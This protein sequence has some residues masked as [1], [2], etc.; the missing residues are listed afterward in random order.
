MTNHPEPIEWTEEDE[1]ELRERLRAV[2][3]PSPED[4]WTPKMQEEL[5]VL[6]QQEARKLRS[7]ILRKFVRDREEAAGFPRVPLKDKSDMKQREKLWECWLIKALPPHLL[8]PFM[9]CA[10]LTQADIEPP[11]GPRK[12]GRKVRPKQ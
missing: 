1:R 3:Q 11:Q 8:D 2:V 10:G 12:K 6:L 7:S 4:L 5:R 9:V